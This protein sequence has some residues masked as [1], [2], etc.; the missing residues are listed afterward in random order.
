M[1][2]PRLHL[3]DKRAYY[4]S[5]LTMSH[6]FLS[7]GTVSIESILRV[8][9]KLVGFHTLTVEPSKSKSREA[10]SKASLFGFKYVG[11]GVFL[12]VSKEQVNKL[13]STY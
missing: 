10:T 2:K 11:T 5:Q 4:V 6:T 7:F 3:L 12:S 9:I 13:A 1:L 8:F